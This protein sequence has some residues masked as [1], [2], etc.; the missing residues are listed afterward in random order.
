[1]AESP[2]TGSR[3]PSPE[4]PNPTRKATA[5]YA[6]DRSPRG[7][8]GNRSHASIDASQAPPPNCPAQ[9]WNRRYRRRRI[10]LSRRVPVERSGTSA[11]I[12]TSNQIGASPARE[13][14]CRIGRD[15]PPTQPPRRPS[16]A[17]QLVMTAMHRRTETATQTEPAGTKPHTA[18]LAADAGASRA[19]H[20]PKCPLSTRQKNLRLGPWRAKKGRAERGLQPTLAASV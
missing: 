12:A 17:P 10:D 5:P 14:T 18:L 7:R 19:S 20:A 11:G 8:F 9:A 2:P 3:A 4:R 6:A 15:R 1:M 13:N 16:E